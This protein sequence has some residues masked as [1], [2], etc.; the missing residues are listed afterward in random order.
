MADIDL[1]MGSVP[2]VTPQ[3]TIDPSLT[4]GG[5]NEGSP[6]LNPADGADKDW[7]SESEKNAQRYSDSSREALRLKEEKESIA[8]EAEEARR[9][10]MTFVTKDRSRFEE[11]IDSKVR[12][13]KEKEHYMNIYDTQIAPTKGSDSSNKA[14]AGVTDRLED[15]TA[16]AVPQRED[17]FRESWMSRMDE[18]EKSKWTEQY[19]A[20]KDF[21]NREE[22]KNL[23]PQVQE[24]I[25]T[26]AA[27]LDEVYSY[28]PKEA[29]EA[30]RKRI[31]SPDDI[32]DEGYVQAV[33]DSYR[34]GISRGVVGATSVSKDRVR[35]PAADEAFVQLE[36]QRRGLSGEKA[37]Q[38]RESY[39]ARISK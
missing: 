13:P 6:N 9:D 33:K 28:T 18:Q 11:F 31:L 23:P 25:K 34:G 29:L 37:E 32:Q 10:L 26:T 20:S 5:N 2:T 7:K 4:A 21:F 8:Q 3:P 15:K 35:L 1:G 39:A 30:A 38:Y 14:L 19:N 36:I 12:S 27:M 17:P 24:S 16:P 22:N